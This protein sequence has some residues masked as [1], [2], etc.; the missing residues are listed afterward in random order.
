[1]LK[2]QRGLKTLTENLSA[3]IQRT[4]ASLNRVWYVFSPRPCPFLT[5]RCMLSRFPPLCWSPTPFKRHGSWFCKSKLLYEILCWETCVCI[6]AYVCVSAYIYICVFV[7]ADINAINNVLASFY[8]R[9]GD[10][11]LPLVW[12]LGIYANNRMSVAIKSPANFP[13]PVFP[14]KS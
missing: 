8:A 6:S 13:R 5:A 12:L 3:N 10:V 1:M 9:K 4:K 7:C 14:M 2:K 11:I